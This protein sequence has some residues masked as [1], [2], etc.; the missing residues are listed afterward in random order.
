[1]GEQFSKL[2]F[3]LA[4]AGSAIGLG[5]CWKVPY[6]IGE[7]GGSAFIILYFLMTLLVGIPILLA[8]ISIGNFSKSDPVNAFK[9][10]ALKGENI[11]KFSGFTMIGGLI[12]LS[13]YTMIIGWI[14]KYA[15][16]SF[17]SLPSNIDASKELFTN[18]ISAEPILQITFFTIAFFCSFYIVS[19]GVKGGIEKM[20]VWLM[21]AFFIMMLAILFY[22]MTM[23][24]FVPAMKYMLIPDF[25]KLTINS[26]LSALGLAFFTL[27]LG[28]GIMITYSASM[29]DK[30]NPIT[31]S[32]FVAIMNIIVS[33]IMGFII[34]TFIFEFNAQPSQGAGLTFISLPTLFGNLGLIGRVLSVIFFIALAFTA[35]TSAISLVEPSVRYLIDQF[36]ISRKKALIYTGIFVYILGILC[37]L[38][39][40][41]GSSLRIFGQDYTTAFDNFASNIIM[42]LGGLL[43]SIFIG[44]AVDKVRLQN[45]FLQ[46]VSE[47]TFKIWYFL[48]K[49]VAPI[50]ILVIFISSILG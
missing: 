46:F 4:V 7:N 32:A 24:G 30:S 22:S 19:K 40:L 9:K 16:V 23:S 36:G 38:S 13:F 42:P 27:S 21:P 17:A 48:V 18:F 45:F 26:V 8:E 3:I 25:T 20:N 43:V 35:I 41:D 29:S 1:M 6:I 11:W 5:A 37:I 12:I 15:I 44:F 14:I 39:N 50:C 10:L 47:K 2:G 49:F 28:V 33:L 31:T 34:F